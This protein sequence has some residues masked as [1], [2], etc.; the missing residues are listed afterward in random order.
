MTNKEMLQML[1]NNTND[2]KS[3]ITALDERVTALENNRPSSAK[4]KN[5]KGTS[6]PKETKEV[7]LENIS[8]EKYNGGNCSWDYYKAVRTSY[9]YARQGVKTWKGKRT[10]PKDFTF[11]K[12]QWEADKVAF[13]TKFPYIKVADRK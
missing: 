12:E 4:Q 7:S 11:N 10:Y 3:S 13:N 5:S 2:I 8:F 6:T 9:C 1:L